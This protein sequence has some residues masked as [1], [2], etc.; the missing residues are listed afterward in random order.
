[1]DEAEVESTFVT[2]RYF[3]TFGCREERGERVHTTNTKVF[4]QPE[5]GVSPFVTTKE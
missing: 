1:M 5:V 3:R 2:K 4:I